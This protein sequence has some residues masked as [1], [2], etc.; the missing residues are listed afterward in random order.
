MEYVVQ[1]G[2]TLYGISRQYGVSVSDLMKANNLSST[3][4]VV[5]SRIKIPRSDVVVYEVKKGDSLYSIGKKYG[6]GVDLIMQYNNLSSNKLNIGDKLY[7]PGV[8][9][10]TSN[11][12][13]SNIDNY[14]IV[15]KGDSLYSIGKKYGLSVEYLK[16]INNLTSNNLTVGQKL[17]LKDNGSVCNIPI[18][19]S[20]YGNGFSGIEYV[21]YVVQKGDNLYSIARRYGVGVESIKKLNNL[22]SDNLSIGQTLKIKEVL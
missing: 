10:G 19:S 17:I 1:R 7:I 15:K 5:G 20:C 22:T 12:T 8:G 16:N 13:D 2:D 11:N 9:D 4:I 14:Y 6:V 18:G 21:T 3:N